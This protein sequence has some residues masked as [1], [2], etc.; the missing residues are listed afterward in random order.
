M[1]REI[2]IYVR[3]RLSKP[4]SYI[5]LYPKGISRNASW[6]SI[7]KHGYWRVLS[8]W[9]LT[10]LVSDGSKA[11]NG[12]ITTVD[13]PKLWDSLYAN[14][15]S[16][17]LCYSSPSNEQMTP[18]KRGSGVKSASSIERDSPVKESVV[19]KNGK[20]EL[21]EEVFVPRNGRHAPMKFSSHSWLIWREKA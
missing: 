6:F 3:R 8:K 12:S 16:L 9:I 13:D 21:S 11:F 15:H 17:A 20:R 14:A 10:C 1:H 4:I 2:C 18:C 19:V 5:S 7:C